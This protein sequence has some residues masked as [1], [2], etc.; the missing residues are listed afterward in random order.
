MVNRY[1]RVKTKC[2]H[3]GVNNCIWI[4]FAIMAMS[5]KEAAKKAR[6]LPR[7]KRHQKYAIDSVVEISLE[8][9]NTLREENEND[10]Y[11]HCKNKKEQNQIKDINKRIVPDVRGE[12]KRKKKDPEFRNKIRG[13]EDKTARKEIKKYK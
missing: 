4:D 11:L 5:G 2:G 6:E 10:P 1:Y 12:A 8:E 13:Q 7:V 3:V 9:F